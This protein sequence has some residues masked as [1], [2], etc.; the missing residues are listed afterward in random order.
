ML[1]NKWGKSNEKDNLVAIG[2]IE[3]SCVNS[4]FCSEVVDFPGIFCI[5]GLPLFEAW[6]SA[7]EFVVGAGE[8]RLIGASLKL[9]VSFF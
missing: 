4:K 7:C 3:G 1:A 2:T 5:V 8:I 9:R 6:C